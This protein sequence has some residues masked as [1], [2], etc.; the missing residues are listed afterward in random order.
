MKYIIFISLFLF[1]FSCHTFIPGG[2]VKQ[3]VNLEK[4]ITFN[5][6]KEIYTKEAHSLGDKMGL[7]KRASIASL[8]SKYSQLK[9]ELLAQTSQPDLIQALKERIKKQSKIVIKTG[10]HVQDRMVLFAQDQAQ[11]GNIHVQMAAS[12]FNGAEHPHFGDDSIPKSAILEYKDDST[13]GPFCQMANPFNA[14]RLLEKAQTSLNPRGF[15]GLSKVEGAGEKVINGYLKFKEKD[16]P[17]LSQQLTMYRH[18]I[19]ST[20]VEAMPVLGRIVND[21]YL[22]NPASYGTV[23]MVAVSA[24]PVSSYGNPSKDQTF[25]IQK[26]TQQAAFEVTVLQGVVEW[27]ERLKSLKYDLSQTSNLFIH[28]TLPG[29]GVFNNK[30]EII[31]EAMRQAVLKYALDIPTSFTVEVY[32]NSSSSK[33]QKIILDINSA[34]KLGVR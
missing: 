33:L 19:E 9:K 12:Q 1:Y 18:Q 29:G 13:Q 25:Q 23:T 16:I 30:E 7:L 26:A 11:T 8:Q 2:E 27:L 4:N 28:F 34:L 32:G 15:N 17:H 24:A 31:F 14:E 21:S 10:A 3:Q 5:R 20:V 6:L 22:Y